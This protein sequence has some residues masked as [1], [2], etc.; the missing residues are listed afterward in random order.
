LLLPKRLRR[1]RRLA[2]ERVDGRA[3]IL[4]GNDHIGGCRDR[5]ISSSRRLAAR[6]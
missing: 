6:Q 2:G 5:S 1:G 4:P 3:D